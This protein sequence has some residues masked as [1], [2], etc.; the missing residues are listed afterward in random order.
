MSQ[1]GRVRSVWNAIRRTPEGAG[2]NVADGGSNAR[3]VPTYVEQHGGVHGRTVTRDLL[4]L[5]QGGGS[6]MLY[7]VTAHNFLRKLRSF[8]IRH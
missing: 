1:K 6:E 5:R 2:I 4:V 7:G 8:R 3:V